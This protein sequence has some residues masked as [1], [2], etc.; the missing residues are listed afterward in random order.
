[1]CRKA[2]RLGLN[3]LAIIIFPQIVL[4][5]QPSYQDDDLTPEAFTAILKD[6]WEYLKNATE[7]LD[8]ETGI[9]GEFETTPEFK[10][11]AAKARQSAVEKLTNYIKENKFDKR[12]FGVWLKLNLI[13]YDA[14]AGVYSVSCPVLIEAPYDIP[15]VVCAVP[16][17]PYVELSDSIRGGYRRASI[18]FTFDPSF[19]WKV[20]RADAMA[21]KADESNMYFKVQFSL[22]MTLENLPTKATLKIIPR[23]I[24]IVNKAKKQIYW[25]ENI[26]TSTTVGTTQTKT[27][28]EPEPIREEVE[29]KVEE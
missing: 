2:F 1:M 8:K 15:T 12:T 9:R 18:H 14:D 16:L 28:T 25:S 19:K 10:T 4:T 20:S 3:L 29:E 17:N 26:K 21:A 11:R 27:K 24:A 13:S 22:D 5:Q 23:S 7:Q 6:Q